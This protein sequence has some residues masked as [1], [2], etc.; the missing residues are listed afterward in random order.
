VWLGCISCQER[1]RF[2]WKVDK[3]KPL[4][5]GMKPGCDQATRAIPAA[6]GPARYLLF[7]PHHDRDAM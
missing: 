3:C 1:L 5:F 6:V 4:F 7:R 2:S